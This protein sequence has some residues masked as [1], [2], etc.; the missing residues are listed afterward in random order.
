MDPVMVLYAKNKESKALSLTDEQ[1]YDM[2]ITHQK[3]YQQRDDLKIDGQKRPTKLLM[4]LM[5]RFL[6]VREIVVQARRKVVARAIKLSKLNY[7]I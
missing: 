4:R 1:L 2:L 5:H 6:M 3:A 7:K